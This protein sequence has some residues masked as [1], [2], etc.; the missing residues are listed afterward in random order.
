VTHR[1]FQ[2]VAAFSGTALHGPR[3]ECE[4][5]PTHFPTRW[6]YFPTT[7]LRFAN[8]PV[9]TFIRSGEFFAFE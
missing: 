4:K 5:R 6:E 7:L 3:C 9:K 8:T 1:D 2:W